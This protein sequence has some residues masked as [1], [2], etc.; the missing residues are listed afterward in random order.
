MNETEQSCDVAG[1]LGDALAVV[2]TEHSTHHEE[3]TQ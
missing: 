1:E 3:L 2:N